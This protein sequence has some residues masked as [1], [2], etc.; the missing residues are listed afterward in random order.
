VLFLS[1]GRVLLAGE[2]AALVAEHKAASLEDLFVSVADE[3]LD[4]DAAQAS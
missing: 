4:P 3:A 1:R 2:P